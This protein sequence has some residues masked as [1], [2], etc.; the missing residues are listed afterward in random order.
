MKIAVYVRKTWIK[1]ISQTAD[2]DKVSPPAKERFGE[3]HHSSSRSGSGSA[4][5][6]SFDVGEDDSLYAPYNEAD[7][8]EIISKSEDDHDFLKLVNEHYNEADLV[9][10]EPMPPSVSKPEEPGDLGTQRFCSGFQCDFN[11]IYFDKQVLQS[12]SQMIGNRRP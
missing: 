2:D 8:K 11:R 7:Q 10:W 5:D 9:Q 3:A 12:S 4:E 1:E 6:I